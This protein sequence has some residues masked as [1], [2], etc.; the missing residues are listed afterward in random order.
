MVVWEAVWMHYCLNHTSQTIRKPWSQLFLVFW[1]TLK[2]C[3]MMTK[4]ICKF[5]TITIT[6]GL[7]ITFHYNKFGTAFDPVHSVC[8]K[9][10]LAPS[11]R[12]FKFPKFKNSCC[13]EK[14][15]AKFN[16]RINLVCNLCFL[17]TCILVLWYLATLVHAWLLL[18][19][20][21]SWHQQAFLA[22]IQIGNS[23]ICLAHLVYK[24]NK[25]SQN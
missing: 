24:N 2:K 4:I 18:W 16:S 25:S 12:Y 14:F 17:P 5:L 20:P 8:N 23:K 7:S 9:R 3:S 13:L 11:S 19:E 6:K 10:R 21:H 15:G 22:L 1:K